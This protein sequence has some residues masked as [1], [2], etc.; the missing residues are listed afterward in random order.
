M[1]KRYYYHYDGLGSVIAIS[2]N[3]G[4]VVEKYEYDVYGNTVIRAPSYQQLTESKH[5]NPYLFTGRRFDTETALEHRDLSQSL[6]KS[7]KVWYFYSDKG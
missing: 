1:Q 3:Y 4:I 6:D 5:A 2:N 7:D